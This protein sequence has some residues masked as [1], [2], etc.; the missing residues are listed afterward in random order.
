LNWQSFRER[1]NVWLYDSKERVLGT[2]QW[3][4]LLVNLSALSVL[5]IYYGYEH[6]AETSA[7]LFEAVKFSFGFYVL[8][9]LVRVLYHFHPTT[10]F[11]ETWGEGLVMAV[12][13]VEGVGDLL[14]GAPPLGQGLAVLMPSIGDFS[15]FLVQG[16]LFVAV[17]MEWMR[18]GSRLPRVRLNPAV[19]FILSFVVLIV[20]GTWLLS[21]PLMSTVEGGMPLVDAFFTATSATCVTGLMSVDTMTYFTSKGHWVLLFL[22]QLGGLNFIAFGSFLALASKFGVAVKQHDVIEDFV[23][24]DNLLGSSGTLGKVV[25]WCLGLEALGAVALMVLWSPEIAFHGLGDRVFSSV[26]HSVSAFNNAG[27]TLFTDGLAHPWVANNWLVHWVITVLVFLGALGMVALFDLFDLRK[28]RERMVQPWKT[29]SFP[30]KIALYFSVILVVLGTVAF[31]ALEW[32]GT[33]AGMSGFG[34]FTTAVFQSVTRTSGFNT[35]DIGAVGMPM[36]FLL[37]VL[38]FIGASSSSTGGGIKT[39]TLAIVLADVW[40]TVRGGDHVQIFKRTISTVLRSRAYSVLLFFLVGNL[41]GVFVLTVTESHLVTSGSTAF[42]D[43]AF[44]HVSAM[45]TVGLSTGITPLLSSWGKVVLAVAMFVGRVGTLT[46][47]FAVGGRT[48]HSHFKYPE[49]HTMVG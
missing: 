45:G 24:S 10:F 13:L 46:V 5:A 27:I 11:K 25:A 33:L 12:L 35:V 8:H 34:K 38:M 18:P 28:L 47:A 3:L 41:V 30:A 14:W 22:I 7:S 2:F 6:D 31:A 16:Y 29:I 32:N 44:E 4:T 1:A 9:Y 42:F 36:L 49:G 48:S 23:N 20:V 21:M 15:T 19:I 17:L 37:L 39:S 40:R 26:F 43:L